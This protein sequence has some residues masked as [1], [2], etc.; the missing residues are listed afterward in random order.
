[1]K[2]ISNYKKFYLTNTKLKQCTDT[3]TVKQNFREIEDV[4]PLIK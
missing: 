2:K 4:M 3:K 1:M